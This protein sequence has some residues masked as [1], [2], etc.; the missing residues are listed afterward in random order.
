[1]DTTYDNMRDVRVS[2]NVLKRGEK[3]M[4]VYETELA[5]P[6]AAHRRIWTRKDP[7]YNLKNADLYGGG[8][9]VQRELKT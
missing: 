5:P 1:M 9:T 8:N 3:R 6:M 2:S 4:V 7:N